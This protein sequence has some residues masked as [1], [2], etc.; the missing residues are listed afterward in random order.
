MGCSEIYTFQ[1][2]RTLTEIQLKK[3]R[4]TE[5]INFITLLKSNASK[6]YSPWLIRLNP[7]G[8]DPIEGISWKSPEGKLTVGQAIN[9]M[10]SGGNVGIAGTSF[11]NLVN[12]DCDGGHIK[13]NDL[14]PTLCVRTRSRIGLHAFYWNIDT[15]KIPNIPTDDKGEVRSRWQ[16]VGL[17]W[18]RQQHRNQGH[19]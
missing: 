6:D 13:V 7:A 9:Y 1:R 12:M 2:W 16:F 11:D 14:K 15:P 5:F 10:A 3:P 17:G 4:V 8:K 18:R 19:H